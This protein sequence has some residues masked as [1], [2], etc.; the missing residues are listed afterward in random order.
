MA[1]TPGWQRLGRLCGTRGGRLLCWFAAFTLLAVIDAAQ[2]LAGQSFEDFTVAW[3]TAL[4][5]G[6][7]S[8]YTL[9]VL[10][11]GVLWLAGRFPFD[12]ARAWR[13]F[14]QHVGF[15]LIFALAYSVTYA[16]LVNGQTSVRG[17]PFVFAETLRKLVIFYTYGNVAM[18]WFI[19]LG[20]QGWHYY[21]RYRERERRALELEGQ[22]ARAQLEALRMQLNPHFLFN[23]LNTIAALIHDQP[24]V[25]DRTIT[26]LSELLRLSLDPGGSLEVP[27]RE[28]LG[29]L[30]RY[31]EIEQT[32]FGD[33][34]RVETRVAEELQEVLVPSLVL[35][36]IVE[37]AIRH[38]I[39]RREEAGRIAIHARRAGDRLVLEVTDNGPGLPAGGT[40]F[41]REGIGLGNTRARLRHLYG[42]DQE[43]AL[44]RATGGGL[45]VRVS[46][47]FR[48]ARDPRPGPD[49]ATGIGSDHRPMEDP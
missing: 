30:D 16:A 27:L 7:E 24:E 35:Q 9:A 22:L 13:W 43:L 18:Y 6:F 21:Q 37:N 49:S 44:D 17:K 11:L 48:S 19:V 25:A 33:R 5:R 3:T 23:T 41:A 40:G 12:R 10:G 14:G 31:L 2:L 15:A 38:G 39:E 32:R 4:R 47:P 1:T 42:A 45:A 26:R 28:E 36:P 34:L 20:H 46:L 8:A 29:F